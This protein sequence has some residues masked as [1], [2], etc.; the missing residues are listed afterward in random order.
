MWQFRT[1][2]HWNKNS[3]P[4]LNP[5]LS[6]SHYSFSLPNLEKMNPASKENTSPTNRIS[7]Y[8][9]M[10][11]W[12]NMIICILFIH[13][14]LGGVRLLLRLMSRERDL[15]RDLEYLESRLLD[16]Y[17]L[18]LLRSSSKSLL[19]DRRRDLRSGDRSRSLLRDRWRLRGGESKSRLRDRCRPRRSKESRSRL[20]LL[21]RRPGG[22]ESRST[23]TTTFRLIVC[24][25]ETADI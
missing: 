12:L 11:K 19:L 18:L 3:S 20:R 7:I 6:A 8:I 23:R 22:G 10:R 5:S 24:K 15:W 13:Y 21:E 16:L 9:Y 2:A 25:L 4:S 1:G 17:R 14:L